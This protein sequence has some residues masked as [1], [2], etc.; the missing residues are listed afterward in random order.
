MPGQTGPSFNLQFISGNSRVHNGHT[1]S[2]S[3]VG[4]S[5][6]GQPQSDHDFS[7]PCDRL[8]RSLRFDQ[9][10]ARRQNLRPP[11]PNTCTWIIDTEEY[12]TWI[13]PERIRTHHGFLWIKGKP[14]AGKST[15]MNYLVEQSKTKTPGA[16]IISFFFN[17][18]GHELERTVAGLY[19]AL[20]LQ[21][22]TILPDTKKAFAELGFAYPDL[23]ERNG[24]QE[25]SLANLLRCVVEKSRGHHFIYFIDA[26]DE[27]PED[28][29]R[30]MVS[31]FQDIGHRAVKKG[32][33]LNICFSSRHY[34]NI[35][36]KKALRIGMDGQRGHVA[37]IQH[38]V[39]TTLMIDSPH[40][41]EDIK[42]RILEKASGVFLWVALAIPKLNKA[43]DSGNVM[44]LNKKLNELPSELSL[45][46][47]DM[48]VRDSEDYDSMLLC[49][50]LMLCSQAGLTFES[51]YHA[52]QAGLG[53]PVLKSSLISNEM[54]RR[55][56]LRSSKGLIEEKACRIMYFIHESVRGFFLDPDHELRNGIQQIWPD[57][58]TNFIGK[59]QDAIK[60]ACLA[61]IMLRARDDALMAD[62]GIR[63]RSIRY[64]LT[65]SYPFLN[66]AVTYVLFHSNEAQSYGVPQ[67]DWIN[68]FPL[69]V[70][71]KLHNLFALSDESEY[72]LDVNMMGT[73]AHPSLQH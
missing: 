52:I 63:D 71:V 70:W 15:L 31:L 49:I 69:S 40:C 34:P 66:Y 67:A 54:M 65:Q 11:S 39:D 62:S 53:H 14:G 23:I 30:S 35:S 60:G 36:I 4:Q 56:I 5:L 37:D 16:K 13:N 41:G 22:M 18:R 26:L 6:P 51:L 27:C 46:F 21:I 68:Q 28:Q 47:H 72:D 45:L 38:Y 10:H 17:A 57:L 12:E 8:F 2:G 44:A 33:R 1:Y 55:Y 9:I 19:R 25:Q 48:L 24:W 32:D 73:T 42:T 58:K 59:S 61:E 64:D 20:L 43:F 3:T 7:E 29:V 50:Q